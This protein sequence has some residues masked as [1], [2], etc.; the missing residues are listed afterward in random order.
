MLR[1][2]IPLVA[3]LFAISVAAGAMAQTE[4]EIIAK[5]LQK[6]EKKHKA[7]V[8]FVSTQF[9]YGI[10]ATKMGYYRD[11]TFSASTDLASFDGNIWP[12]AGI[13]RSSQFGLNLGMMFTSKIALSLGFEYWYP[14]GTSYTVD[15]N[16]TIGVLEESG[17][18]INDEKINV[19]GFKVGF[20]YYLF[21]S[22]DERGSLNSIAFKLGGGAGY[23]RS[24][25]NLWQAEDES[26]DP[27]TSGAPAFWV[28]GGAEYPIGFFDMT[29]GAGVGYFYLNFS[30]LKA[31]NESGGEVALT[32]LVDDSNVEFD[33][34]GIRG[35]VEL[36]KFI[37]W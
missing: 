20:D 19:Y 26:T 5:Y 13:Y 11:I 33:F 18:F 24:S 22:P 8:G 15:Y 35:M 37:C 25:W 21:N 4:D 29:I 23:F 1:K 27:V 9:D 17:R 34:S 30:E 3:F 16:S 2:L 12:H 31:Y 10:L 14:I 36:K 7:K 32:Y 6:T 28:H